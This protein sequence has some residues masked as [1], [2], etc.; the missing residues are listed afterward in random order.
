MIDR[1]LNASGMFCYHS[2]WNCKQEAIF[3]VLLFFSLIKEQELSETWCSF[4]HNVSIFKV[5][6]Y[7]N[8]KCQ[9]S[10]RSL[11]FE[12]V[13][14]Q[15]TVVHYWSVYMQN[16]NRQLL[17][18]MCVFRIIF[19][20]IAFTLDAHDYMKISVY[21]LIIFRVRRCPGTRRNKTE[22]QITITIWR[23]KHQHLC[24]DETR[25]QS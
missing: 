11:Q 21:G 16:S 8:N 6:L 20:G 9:C 24:N 4:R 1:I 15:L 2:M 13:L 7:E 25:T 22:K 14:N 19:A 12:Y 3:W 5:V 18:P 10:S 17:Y 23:T